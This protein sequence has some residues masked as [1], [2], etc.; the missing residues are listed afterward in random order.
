M[1]GRCWRGGAQLAVWSQ[2]DLSI[3]RMRLQH[4]RDEIPFSVT[5]E[6]GDEDGSERLRCNRLRPGLHQ[7]LVFNFH[8][9]SCEACGWGGEP[10]RVDHAEGEIAH[11]PPPPVGWWDVYH[12][13]IEVEHGVPILN[14]SAPTRPHIAA[15]RYLVR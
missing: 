8:Y 14:Q 15:G 1:R 10:R 11:A 4:D 3:R 5:G 12:R 9:M 13:R 6:Q 7:W 2:R